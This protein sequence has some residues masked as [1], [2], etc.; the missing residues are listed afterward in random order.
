MDIKFPPLPPPWDFNPEEF[1]RM[2]E[3]ASAEAALNGREWV[4]ASRRPCPD[5]EKAKR[6]PIV[7]FRTDY[8]RIEPK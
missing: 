7:T 4:T 6:T 2:I 3:K 5:C 1:F 8:K